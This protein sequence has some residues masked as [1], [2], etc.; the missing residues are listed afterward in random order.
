[1]QDLNFKSLMRITVFLVFTIALGHLM[2][3]GKQIII[4]LLIAFFL[5]FLLLPLVRRLEKWRFPTPLA[6]ITALLSIT[7]IIGGILTLFGTQIRRFG[8]DVDTISER[9]LSLR[10]SL[11]EPLQESMADW[12]S[13][14]LYVLVE[15]NMGSIFQGLSGFVSSFTFL[16]IIPVYIILI[17]I[18]RDVFRNFIIR[19]ME[20]VSPSNEEASSDK[21]NIRE[22]IPSISG[23]IQSYIV[24]MFYVICILF[25]LN[26]IALTALGV[27]HALL[28]AAFAAM[29]NIIPFVGPLVGSLLPALYALVTMDSLFYPFAVV[30]AFVVIQ[31]AESY[32]IT[33]NI[34]GRNVHLNPM[35]T[36]FTLFLG[37]SLWGVIGMIVFIPLVAILKEVLANINGLEPYA[38]VLGTGDDGHSDKT[39]GWLSRLSD[40]VSEW[41]KNRKS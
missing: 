35:V 1:M 33:P 29:L 37:A 2:I 26:S 13:D 40:K 20:N 41:W 12:S 8:R 10:S 36:L 5:A 17:L 19:V 24:G 3:I 15:E 23:I 9:L 30:M 38:Y 18:Y 4:P 7:V 32:L 22:I 6:A 11:P 25:V 28:F 39:P 14:D 34:V 16:V 31:T 27:E 21:K